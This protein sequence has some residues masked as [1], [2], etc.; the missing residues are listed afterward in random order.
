M[1]LDLTHIQR[2]IE[3]GSRVLDLGC[4]NGEFLQRLAK[5]R[6]VRGLGLE[7]DP[8][9]ITNAVSRGLD[10][11]EQDMDAGLGNFPDQSFDTVVM[12]HALQAVHYPDRV[13]EEML[14]IGRQGI[15]TFPNFA[16]WRCRL[17][18]GSRGRMP[19]SRFMPYNWYDT[20]NIH[21]CTVTDFEALC[22]E[23]GI[24]ILARDMVGNTQRRPLLASAWPNLFAVTAIYLISR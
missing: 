12:A 19:V 5:E 6:Q 9:K 16:H 10:I 2:W 14:R 18:L 11:V 15:V 17:Y 4:G 8:D 22:E 23:R 13:L 3:P 21:F 1:R 24:R 7:I 20:P